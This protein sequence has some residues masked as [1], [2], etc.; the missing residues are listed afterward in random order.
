MKNA[1]RFGSIRFSGRRGAGERREELLTTDHK[2]EYAVGYAQIYG[3]MCDGFAPIKDLYR[4][5]I[6]ALCRW[7]NTRGDGDIITA[8]VIERLPSAQLR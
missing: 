6:F 1:Y 8:A 5:E 4:T 3:D 2:T 7:R